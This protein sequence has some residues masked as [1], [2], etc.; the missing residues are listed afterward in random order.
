MFN[1]NSLVSRFFFNF[2]KK[3][4]PVTFSVMQSIVQPPYAKTMLSRLMD[5][6]EPLAI[7]VLTTMIYAT[8]TTAL[9]FTTLILMPFM[10]TLD[11]CNNFKKT[12]KDDSATLATTKTAK[13]K[14]SNTEP[15]CAQAQRPANK[16]T[17]D[18]QAYSNGIRRLYYDKHNKP[19]YVQ[20]ARVVCCRPTPHS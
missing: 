20:T 8:L 17:C 3:I 2:A 18:Y 10:L 14:C 1:I 16:K 6:S 5:D 15:P 13:Q 7:R 4:F 19:A 11:L 9:F 12:A